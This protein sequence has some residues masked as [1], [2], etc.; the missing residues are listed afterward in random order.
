MYTPLHTIVLMMQLIS[1]PAT[2]DSEA[3]EL[4]PSLHF[5]YLHASRKT[6]DFKTFSSSE[7]IFEACSSGS[8]V[9]V[10]YTKTERSLKPQLTIGHTRTSLSTPFWLWVL[11]TIMSL[12][13]YWLIPSTIMR[14][15]CLMSFFLA[16]DCMRPKLCKRL[17]ECR[18]RWETLQNLPSRSMSICLISRWVSAWLFMIR[19]GQPP[20]VVKCCNTTLNTL[21]YVSERNPTIYTWIIGSVVGRRLRQVDGQGY[22]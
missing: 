14:H 8:S 22:K 21:V 18:S 12:T 2:A 17:M 19:G 3:C 11:C 1:M 6:S 9:L 10:C 13:L 20:A 4:T 5:W 15:K 7:H 16:L